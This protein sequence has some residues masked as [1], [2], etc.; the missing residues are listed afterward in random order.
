MASCASGIVAH[1]WCQTWN[2]S[3]QT[4]SV[5]VTP[6]SRAFWAVRVVSSRMILRVSDLH[7]QGR[8]TSEISEHRRRE[9]R[10][11]IVSAQVMIGHEL[12]DLVG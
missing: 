6:A 1:M 8:Q 11:A 5:T 4:S 3:G 2:I 12:Q 7:E 10:A 9:R